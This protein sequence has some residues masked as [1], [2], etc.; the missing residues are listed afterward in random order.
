MR[1]NQLMKERQIALIKG[2]EEE[3]ERITKELAE[4]EERA[5]ELS[6]RSLSSTLSSISFINERNRKRNVERAEEAIL[7]EIRASGG[8]KTEDPFT[9]RSTRPGKSGSYRPNGDILPSTTEVLSAPTSKALEG[10]AA[11]SNHENRTESKDK[12]KTLI[13]K[14]KTSDLFSAHDFDIKIDLE[15][16]LPSQPVVVTPKPVA[17]LKEA[18]RRSLNLEDYKKKRGLI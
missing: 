12:V 11:A 18:P 6:K 3:T 4:L 1:K 10:Q 15:V 8:Q 5:D 16:P 9:R 2:E 7:E 13:A 14:P 17:N